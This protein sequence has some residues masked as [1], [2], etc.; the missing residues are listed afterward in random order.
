[1]L[2]LPLNYPTFPAPLKHTYLPKAARVKQP[3]PET[4]ATESAA[5]YYRRRDTMKNTETRF[6]K[7]PGLMLLL[8]KYLHTK[9]TTW[10]EL[11]INFNKPR[12]L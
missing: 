2:I 12:H 11:N 7:C 8:Q 3:L 1:M 10:Y 6:E 9:N 4:V 5:G